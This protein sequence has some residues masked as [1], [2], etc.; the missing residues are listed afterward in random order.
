MGQ[1]D[2]HRA[3]DGF[4]H[5]VAALDGVQRHERL[6]QSFLPVVISRAYLVACHAELGTFAEGRALG[7]E[8]LR[9]AEA[10]DHPASVMI[11]SWGIGLTTLRQGDVARALPRL[12]RAVGICQEVGLPFWFPWMASALGAAYTLGGRVVDAVLLLTQALAQAMATER[13]VPQVSCR[14]F[15]GEAQVLAGHLEEA[16]TLTEYTLALARERQERGHQAYALRLLGDIAT[17]RTPP[18]VDQAATHYQQALA[19]AAELG[20]RPLQ[21]HCHRSLGMLYATAG[22]HE[23]ARAELSTAIALYRTMEMTFWLPETEA[24]LAQVD[25]Q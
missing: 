23:Q 18:D 5:T 12:E 10:V 7:D 14:L 25:A 9:I 8:A 2:Y 1:G 11:A 20:M 4:R 22:Q 15:L 21:A 3:I 16:H 6:G 13:V 19:L 24:A 17:H